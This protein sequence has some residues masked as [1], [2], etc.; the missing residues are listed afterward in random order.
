M[1]AKDHKGKMYKTL[2]AMAEAWGIEYRT[3]LARL[4]AGWTIERALTT[5]LHQWRNHAV[6]HTGREFTS[7]RKMAKAWGISPG[8]FFD[9]LYMGWSIEKA[10]TTIYRKRKP[11]HVTKRDEK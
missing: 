1:I 9:R 5:P 8:V 2:R 6:D 11:Y 7:M 4:D 3:F 10:L